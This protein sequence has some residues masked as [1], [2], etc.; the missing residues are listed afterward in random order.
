M[1][2]FETLPLSQFLETA[3][4]KVR[5]SKLKRHAKRRDE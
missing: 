5:N 3:H 1:D 4:H 2:W